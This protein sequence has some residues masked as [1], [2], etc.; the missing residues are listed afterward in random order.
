MDPTILWSLYKYAKK[1]P[2][3]L[4]TLPQFQLCPRFGG[5][6][7]PKPLMPWNLRVRESPAPLASIADPA[8]GCSLR[9]Q[10]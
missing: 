5:G 2:L 9:V 10:G 1:L 6:V 7:N 8:R 3:I 4:G